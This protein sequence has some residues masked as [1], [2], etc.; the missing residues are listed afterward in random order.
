[1]YNSNG[2]SCVASAVSRTSAN[3]QRKQNKACMLIIMWGGVKFSRT[4]HR[5]KNRVLV[6]R[7]HCTLPDLMDPC[8][9]FQPMMHKPKLVTKATYVELL[10]CAITMRRTGKQ[11]S[12]WYS[13]VLHLY[14]VPTV[15]GMVPGTECRNVWWLSSTSEP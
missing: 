5:W 10:S 7:V 14:H 11:I 1:M 4:W 6:T 13:Q 12:N 2:C 3:L 8:Y 15:P 9:L